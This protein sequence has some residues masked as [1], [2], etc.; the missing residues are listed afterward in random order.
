M[1]QHSQH[2]KIGKHVDTGAF[3]C[4]YSIFTIDGKKGKVVI[5][6]NA[7]IESH[8]VAMPVVTLGENSINGVFSFVNRDLL[9]SVIAFGSP[10]GL[11]RQL[12]ADEQIR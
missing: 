9:A 8:C 11:F 1:V 7:R 10:V 12:T 5:K 6:R 3:A 4:M 2:L